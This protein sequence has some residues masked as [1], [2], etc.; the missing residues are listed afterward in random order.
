M[1]PTKTTEYSQRCRVFIGSRCRAPRRAGLARDSRLTVFA[2]SLRPSL[3]E[4]V[5]CVEAAQGER[6]RRTQV[7]RAGVILWLKGT[8]PA[9]YGTVPPERSRCWCLEPKRRAR[10]ILLPHEMSGDVCERFPSF[11][12]KSSVHSLVGVDHVSRP[13]FSPSISVSVDPAYDSLAC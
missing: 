12:A 11:N 10:G 7:W 6:G 3:S 8:G 1:N 5:S 2:R 9:A 4:T 13:H